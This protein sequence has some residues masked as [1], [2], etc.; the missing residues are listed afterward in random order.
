M[1][2]RKNL[3]DLNAANPDS[4]KTY[5]QDDLTTK[6]ARMDYLARQ[7]RRSGAILD[8]WVDDSKVLVKD[9]YNRIHNIRLMA[10]LEKVQS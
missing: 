2:I 1:K 3:K 7:L 10:D 4:P 5:F 8:T 6:R 9:K